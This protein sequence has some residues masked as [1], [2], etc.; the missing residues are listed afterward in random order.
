MIYFGKTYIQK[1][2]KAYSKGVQKFERP[3]YLCYNLVKEEGD[4]LDAGIYYR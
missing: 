2:F 1:Y 4:D 3:Y